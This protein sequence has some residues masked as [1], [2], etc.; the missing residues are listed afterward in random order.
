M[1]AV[2][3]DADATGRILMAFLAGV[4]WLEPTA[5]AGPARPGVLINQ[6]MLHR[7]YEFRQRQFPTLPTVIGVALG[8][9][10]P[11]DGDLLTIVAAQFLVIYK[12][13]YKEVQ[14]VAF[15]TYIFLFV[16]E[17][18]ADVPRHMLALL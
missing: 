16:L 11:A 2:L 14:G 8:A 13:V 10:D 5:I 9:S 4:V 17:A 12:S 15:R 7:A 1:V 6:H 3:A 18:G